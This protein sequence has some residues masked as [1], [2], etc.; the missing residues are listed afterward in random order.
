[1][2]ASSPCIPCS[3]MDHSS[4]LSED[5]IETVRMTLFVLLPNLRSLPVVILAIEQVATLAKK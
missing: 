1:M 4:I 2:S 5:E 3:A